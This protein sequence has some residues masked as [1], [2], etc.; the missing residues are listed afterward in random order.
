MLIVWDCVRSYE[1]RGL[2]LCMCRMQCNFGEPRASG[3]ILDGCSGSFAT[4]S[5][6]E[7]MERPLF[8]DGVLE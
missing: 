1:V 7:S 5:S 6:T 2:V 8:S 3:S 4:F